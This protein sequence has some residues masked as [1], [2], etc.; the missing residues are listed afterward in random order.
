[1]EDE[2]WTLKGKVGLRGHLIPPLP[3]SSISE[4][5]CWVLGG[6]VSWSLPSAQLCLIKN[7]VL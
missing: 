4:A 3:P 7:T 1:M 5:P 2:T 6:P